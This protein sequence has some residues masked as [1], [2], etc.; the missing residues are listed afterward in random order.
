MQCE[1]KCKATGE[2]CRRRAVSGRA[3]CQVHGGKSLC[4][5]VHANFIDA[6][7]YYRKRLPAH[8]KASAAEL[9]NLQNI[10]ELG[11][12]I[13]IGRVRVAELLERIRDHG[14]GTWK[15][16]ADAWRGLKQAAESDDAQALRGAQQHLDG[17]IRR[18]VKVD[19]AWRLIDS[20]RERTARLVGVQAQREEAARSSLKGDQAIAFMVRLV[21]AVQAA[22]ARHLTDE[23][24]RTLTADELQR[25]IRADLSEA[26]RRATQ[27]E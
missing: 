15:D 18:G 10:L 1:A 12:E 14:G 3:V 25:R 23:N 5:P 21:Q 26:C 22:H 11:G 9:D 13:E 7:A 2:Q 17:V 8:L 4:G 19:S 27:G 24:L 20:E 16:V 6:R